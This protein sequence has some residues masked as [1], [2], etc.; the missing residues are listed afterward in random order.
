M[1]RAYL[2]AGRDLVISGGLVGDGEGS[3]HAGRNLFAGFL[4]NSTVKVGG[5]LIV[6]EAI[7]HSNIEWMA[8]FTSIKGVGKSL[9]ALR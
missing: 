6:T 7:L 4:E 9:E 3:C 1:G 5:N 8:T 2:E